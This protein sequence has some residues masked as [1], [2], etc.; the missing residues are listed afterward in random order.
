MRLTPHFWLHEFTESQTAGRL[1]IDNTPS[2][3][4]LDNLRTLANYLEE[5]RA[6]ADSPIIVTSGFR[7]AALNEAVGGVPTSFHRKGLA[8]DIYAPNWIASGLFKKVIRGIDA[9]RLPVPCE[10]FDEFSRWVHLAVYPVPKPPAS[11]PT[12]GRYRMG[13]RG[14]K[15][16]FPL[17]DFSERWIRESARRASG[18]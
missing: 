2:P 8:A 5:V 10:V 16:Y 9:G 17:E 4:E 3:G 11:R 1:A 12:C 13:E 18:A 6:L 7:C 15:R 14:R